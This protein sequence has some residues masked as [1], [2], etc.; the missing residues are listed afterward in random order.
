[1][2]KELK[3]AIVSF[4]KNREDNIDVVL[5]GEVDDIIS[6]ISAFM[7]SSETAYKIVK[8]SVEVTEKYLENKEKNK[9]IC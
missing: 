3:D 1:M 5:E 6:M 7:L 9:D 8:S 4:I 2:E